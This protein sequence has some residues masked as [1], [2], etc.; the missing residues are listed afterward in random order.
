[1]AD[2]APR[3]PPPT[4]DERTADTSPERK[5]SSTDE[6]PEGNLFGQFD[7]MVE[8]LLGPPPPVSPPEPADSP[9]S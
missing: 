1:M 2:A 8:A 6:D 4:V 5:A 9:P 3:K 7:A